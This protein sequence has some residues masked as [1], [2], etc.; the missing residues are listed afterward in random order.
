MA[1]GRGIAHKARDVGG[2]HIFSEMNDI[3]NLKTIR[4]K[5]SDTLF[6]V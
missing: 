6:H 2:W 4:W 5:S 3:K 1:G